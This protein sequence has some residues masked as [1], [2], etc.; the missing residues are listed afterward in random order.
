MAPWPCGT[1]G[2]F[3]VWEGRVAHIAGTKKPSR[4][5]ALVWGRRPEGRQVW[6]RLIV[7]VFYLGDCRTSN[8]V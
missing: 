7:G 3:W 1:R 8:Q 5:W 2:T 4:D 6:S